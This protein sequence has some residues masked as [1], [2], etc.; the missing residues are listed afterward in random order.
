MTT[1]NGY[2]NFFA[3]PEVVNA[4]DLSS[5]DFQ[6]KYGFVKPEKTDTNL[7]LGCLYAKRSTEAGL[8]LQ[9]IGYQTIV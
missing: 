9:K 6:E 1:D 4:F 8:Y 5:H 7:V 3:V 2:F